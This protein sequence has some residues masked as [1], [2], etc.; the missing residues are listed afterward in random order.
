VSARRAAVALAVVVLVGLCALL[1]LAPAPHGPA[2]APFHTC[3]VSAPCAPI[4][5]VT[6]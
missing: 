3:T 4:G 6:R 2:V 5:V 1:A